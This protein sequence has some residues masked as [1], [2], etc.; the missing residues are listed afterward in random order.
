MRQ[1]GRDFSPLASCSEAERDRIEAEVGGYL[2]ACAANVARLE[3]SVPAVNG[4]VNATAVAHQH[5]VVRA[6]LTCRLSTACC[7]CTFHKGPD[8]SDQGPESSC[9]C[10]QPSRL[11]S[12]LMLCNAPCMFLSCVL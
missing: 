8:A 7:R 10:M 4:A 9:A 6:V 11:C 5:G 2:K 3:G 1:H 12:Q